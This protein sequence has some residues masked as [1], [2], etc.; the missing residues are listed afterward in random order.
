MK[1][2]KK[3]KV[4]KWKLIVS[5][6][7]LCILAFALVFA[8]KIETIIGYN[9]EFANNQTSFS[10][11]EKSAYSVSYIDVGQG[12]SS[13]VELP[14]GKN[15]LI[16]GGDI[17]YGETVANFLNDRNV[18]SIDYLI[19][20][21]ADSDHIGGLNHVLENFEVKNIYRPFQ[22]SYNDD[23]N[24]PSDVED[25][26]EVFEHMISL[27][28]NS[29]KVCKITTK[30]YRTFI[31]N[32]YNETYQVNGTVQS[33]KVTVFY[34]GLKISGENYE[35]EFYAPLKRDENID[36]STMSTETFGFATSGFG[37]TS[38]SSNDNSSIFTLTCFDDVFM[39]VGDSRYT[40]DDLNDLDYSEAEFINSLTEAEKLKLSAVDVLLLGHHGSKYSTSKELLEIVS[41]MFVVV[42]AGKDNSYGH[43]H[44][45]VLERL[46]GYSSLQSDYL[47]RTDEHGD[48]AFASVEGKLMY[49]IESQENGAKLTISFRMLCVT[50]TISLIL[51]I[52]SIRVRKPRR[53]RS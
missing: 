4:Q 24:Q 11:I 43:P 13:Y 16:D 1:A 10:E 2:N 17:E 26:G 23:T 47:L 19:A 9:P 35:I 5:G 21:H 34:D 52:F 41:P 20:T 27:Y 7:L 46:K 14:D 22:I 51:L 36:V 31:E 44:P 28:G 25:L 49:S 53:T 6:V 39:F 3:I 45:E 15:V 38:S 30:V 42:S 8:D 40:E 37:A 33:S 48:I 18:S 12:N 50:I 32:I 29:H